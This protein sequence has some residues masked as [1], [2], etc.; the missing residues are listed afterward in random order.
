VERREATEER[1]EAGQV[2][3]SGTAE[4]GESMSARNEPTACIDKIELFLYFAVDA[5]R[6]LSAAETSSIHYEAVKHP[7]S[8]KDSLGFWHPSHD[9]STASP[10]IYMQPRPDGTVRR[11]YTNPSKLHDFNTYYL[12]LRCLLSIDDVKYAR[13][14]RIDF[15][16]DYCA[17]LPAVIAGTHVRFKRCAAKY[18]SKSGAGTGI[19][20]GK[21]PSL[22]AIYDKRHKLKLADGPDLTRIEVR[23]K[24]PY[25]PMKHLPE[26]P[27]L[28]ARLPSTWKRFDPFGHISL[29]KVSLKDFCGLDCTATQARR[30]GQLEVMLKIHGYSAAKQHLNENKNFARDYLPFTEN[31]AW[32]FAQPT[33]VLRKHLVEFFRGWDPKFSSAGIRTVNSTTAGS[34]D[35]VRGGSH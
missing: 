22:V 32:P 24:G 2:A 1:R 28:R 21:M 19:E 20:L 12:M 10:V 29:K 16:V 7:A 8:G 5:K 26:L 14:S 13:I 23:L 18:S 15:A 3:R 35:A 30:Y 31:E 6:I 9:V 11:L 27:K 25:V 33:D 4:A 17:S 34:T